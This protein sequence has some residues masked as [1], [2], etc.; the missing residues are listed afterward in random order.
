MDGKSANLLFKVSGN[1]LSFGILFEKAEFETAPF[2]L[3]ES[4]G[5]RITRDPNMPMSAKARFFHRFNSCAR[6][7]RDVNFSRFKTKTLV[8]P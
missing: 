8:E 7:E 5:D 6:K 4:S 1:D 3:I 2:Q